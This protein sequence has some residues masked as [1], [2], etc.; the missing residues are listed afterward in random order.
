[1][2]SH[3]EHFQIQFKRAGFGRRGVKG[4][5]SEKASRQGAQVEGKGGELACKVPAAPRRPR[6]GRTAAAP[7]LAPLGLFALLGIASASNLALTATCASSSTPDGANCT[8]AI[9][10]DDA[11]AARTAVERNPWFA[12]DLGALSYVESI[13]IEQPFAANSSGAPSE[14][15]RLDK[16]RVRLFNESRRFPAAVG[17]ETPSF[18]TDVHSRFERSLTLAVG[19]MGR[20]LQIERV[21]NADD[22]PA[23]LAIGELQVWGRLSGALASPPPPRSPAPPSPPMEGWEEMLV[24]GAPPAAPPPSPSRGFFGRSGLAPP[25]PPPPPP[26]F[27]RLVQMSGG[28]PRCNGTFWWWCEASDWAMLLSLSL[29]VACIVVAVRCVWG[30]LEAAEEVEE[31]DDS[32]ARAVDVAECGGVGSAHFGKEPFEPYPALGGP[33][34]LHTARACARRGGS[35]RAHCQ[36]GSKGAALALPGGGSSARS[37]GGA[38]AGDEEGVPGEAGVAEEEEEEEG[39]LTGGWRPKARCA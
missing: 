35:L 25:P 2:S 24:E 23:A 4:G 8:L 26:P 39:A 32:C 18:D 27:T 9:N 5:I 17:A 29:S 22:S 37:G 20:Y 19:A 1:M 33:S 31:D 14:F 11:T 7:L 30:P 34:I 6:C 3:M 15:G 28:P 16:F 13:R 38:L 12:L 10:G 21:S 36:A